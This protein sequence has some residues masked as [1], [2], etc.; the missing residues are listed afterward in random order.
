M[1]DS[2]SRYELVSRRAMLKGSLLV[3][4]L[5]FAPGLACSSSGSDVLATS[6]STTVTPSG[7]AGTTTRT[8]TTDATASTTTAPKA[9][10]TSTPTAATATGPTL[11]SG[12]Q[13]TISFS[14][15]P[16]AGG[17]RVNSPFVAVWI[18]DATGALLR[19]VS[20][21][22]KASESKYVNELRRWYS[23]DRARVAKGG[24]DT[25]RTISGATRVA[26]SYSVT[27]DGK[28]NAGVLA[29]QGDYFV[30]IEAARE[31]G[32]YELIRESITIGSTAFQKQL[33]P[34]GELTA[35][36]VAFVA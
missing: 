11:P 2:E 35:A 6:S 18:E 27:W 25:M 32:P 14:F 12:G 8:K 15:T 10:A 1:S 7:T 34:S 24:A 17:G 30:C 3:G 19:T 33:A 36:S 23:V 22:F 31:H 26:G 29:A 9:N 20:L 13:L 16:A 5:A 4:T 21:W 28:N